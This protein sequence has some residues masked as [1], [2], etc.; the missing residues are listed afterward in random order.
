MP[1]QVQSQRVV[2]QG[3]LN[4][5]QNFLILSEDSPGTAVQL[6]NYEASITGGYRRINGFT[7]YDPDFDTVTSAAVPAEGKVLGLV[8]FENTIIAARKSVGSAVYRFYNY[9]VSVGWTAYTTGTTQVSTGVDIVRAETF[10]IQGTNW[11]I[12][13]DGVNHALAFD[14]TTWYELES[15]NSG[16]SGSPGGDQIID[17]PSVVTFFK[18]SVLLGRDSTTPDIAAYSAP[19]DPLTWTAAAGGG[20]MILSFD[21]IQMKAFR[22]E[23]YIFGR[24]AIKKAIPD[25]SAGFVLQDVTNNIGCVAA[26]SVVE[27][28]GNLNFLSH[29]GVRTV[30]GTNKIGDVELSS[31]SQT[32][33]DRITDL[34]NDHDLE[35][36]R[37]LVIRSKS[38]FRYFYSNENTEQTDSVGI[39]GVFRHI[40]DGF[41]WEFGDLKGIRASVCWS[42]YLDNRE[43]YLHGDYNG[44]IYRQ[45][46]GNSF[47]GSNILAIFTHPYLDFGDTTIRKTMRTL[48]T[49]LKAEGDITLH[50]GIKYDWERN[51]VTNPASY[52]FESDGE[53]VQYDAGY[54]YDSGV[55]Y[56]GT[57]QPVFDLNIQGSGYAVQASIVSDGIFAPYTIQGFVYEFTTRGGQ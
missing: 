12:F 42:G 17:A 35:N 32:I 38:Q 28:G 48:T 45:E 2:C 51:T 16:G 1:D 23:C 5:S 37:S 30:A 14:G 46:Q 22:D 19:N 40:G 31:L 27:V 6:I 56:G 20:Q 7:D 52:S 53:V 3:G 13:V 36:L 26:D 43:V 9:Q 50:Y 21:I 57:N 15:G 11:V 24:T 25:A 44:K 47:D 4:T 34:N 54:T 49:F 55:R 18:G 41:I 10:T 8:V 29:D 39:V 33:Q